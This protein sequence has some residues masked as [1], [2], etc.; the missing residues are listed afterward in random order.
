MDKRGI[1]PLI[2]T[3]MLIG[4]T[5]VI[6][7]V[8]FGFG[9]NVLYSVQEDQELDLKEAGLVNYDAYYKDS[10][11]N[12]ED[13][14][15][16]YNLLFS[17]NEGFPLKFSVITHANGGMHLSDSEDYFFEP[18]EQKIFVIIFPDKLGKANYAEVNA[19]V[20]E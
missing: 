4:M 19:F 18:F 9:H 5:M 20:V 13:G 11:C 8:V 3:T 14:E 6:A 10:V 7:V 15:S 17:S 2:A 12:V 1:S 16:C